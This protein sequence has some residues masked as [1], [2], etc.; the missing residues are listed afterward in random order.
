MLDEPFD[1]LDDDGIQR[2]NELLAEQALRG[3]SALL[4]SH[5]PLG[6][7]QPTPM[8]F[9]LDAALA[10]ATRAAAAPAR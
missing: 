1:A 10:V 8:I 5:Q 6:L 3:G 4:T 9:D 2:L 7:Q